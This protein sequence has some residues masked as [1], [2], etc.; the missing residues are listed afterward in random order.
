MSPFCPPAP[1]GRPP[2][3]RL[4]AHPP[5]P[6]PTPTPSLA[7]TL[8]HPPAPLP[9]SRTCPPGLPRP[10]TRAPACPARLLAHP[11]A[12]RLPPPLPAATRSVRAIRLVS[13]TAPRSAD[14]RRHLQPR[15]RP[16]APPG[17]RRH[18]PSRRRPRAP[19]VTRATCRLADGLVPRRLPGPPAV[20]PT[21]R[22]LAARPRM[23][24]LAGPAIAPRWPL[25][26]AELTRSHPTHP[27]SMSIY[28]IYPL[29]RIYGG[30]SKKIGETNLCRGNIC[31]R[32]AKRFHVISR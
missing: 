15:Q 30:R 1:P 5:A 10:S 6:L 17:F 22:A 28:P 31:F 18:L 25:T 11:T 2:R 27:R 8:A 12:P 3:A 21:A 23:P 32:C 16:R 19:P 4:L 29:C 7:P 13:L 20:S 14:Y 26:P 9:L 24:R